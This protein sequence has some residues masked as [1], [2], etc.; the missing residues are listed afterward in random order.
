MLSGLNHLTLAVSSLAPSVAFYQQLLGM[1]LHARWDSGAYL[2]CG[3]L[4]LCLSLDPQR[5]ITPPEE[6]DYTHYAFTVTE[7]DF[8]PL[9]QRLEQ[10]GVTVWKQNKSEGASFYFLDPDG[11][12][13]ELHVG[14]LAARLAAC[15][16]KP[17]AGMVFTSDEA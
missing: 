11:H 5:R 17:Y 6:S 13:L 12:K 14:S 2:S 16:E 9:S 7:E 4:W 8:E 1:R 15:R 3:D 10:A